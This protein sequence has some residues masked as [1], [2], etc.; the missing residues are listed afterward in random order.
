MNTKQPDSLEQ[1]VST[2]GML[3]SE[4]EMYRNYDG[5]D[6]RKA[7]PLF[8]AMMPFFT[9]S[10]LFSQKNRVRRRMLK[11]ILKMPR[12]RQI[13]RGCRAEGGQIP[14]LGMKE[15]C[16]I[17]SC[18]EKQGL[19]NCSECGSF[20]CNKIMPVAELASLFPHN[21]KITNCCVIRRKGLETWA[22]EDSAG[23]RTH[24]FQGKLPFSF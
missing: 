10:G 5:Q 19:H 20:P 22:K 18:A 8:I 24:Y 3:C 4:C 7:K 11:R 2:C 1:I 16:A 21:A 13:C 23:I 14:V 9:L 6:P 17:Y 15:P 12:E